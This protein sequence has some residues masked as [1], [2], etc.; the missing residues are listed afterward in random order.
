METELKDEIEI[1]SESIERV[2]D[3]RFKD[4]TGKVFGRL[5]VIKREYLP[6][7]GLKMRCRA[8]FRCQCSCGN[9]I[10]VSG[11]ML[12]RGTFKECGVCAQAWEK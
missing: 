2:R 11:N 9:K 8:I 4:E 6:R 10:S 5:T 1:H 12:R 7:D 3:K